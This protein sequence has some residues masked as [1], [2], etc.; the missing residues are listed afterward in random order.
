MILIHSVSQLNRLLLLCTVDL[1]LLEYDD[2]R[3][4]G[5]EP[6]RF[7]PK[8]NKMVV[9][10]LVSTKTGKLEDKAEVVGRIREAARFAPLDQL[11]V[12]PQC[13]FASTLEGNELTEE[14]QFAKI[15]LCQEI[16]ET[17]WGKQE[18]LLSAL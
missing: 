7:L 6:L 17:V 11:S 5:F 18:W 13:G 3:S 15:R 2:A 4:G 14:E 1:Y 16:V 8:G 9:L 12:G 10:G